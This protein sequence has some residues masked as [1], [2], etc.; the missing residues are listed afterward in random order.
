MGL[1]ELRTLNP[2]GN[3]LLAHIRHINRGHLQSWKCEMCR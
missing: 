3:P 2:D 1:T